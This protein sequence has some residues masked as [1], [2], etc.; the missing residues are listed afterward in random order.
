MPSNPHNTYKGKG[1]T[2]WG[3]FLGT[4]NLGSKAKQKS[5]ALYEEA[6]KVIQK[7]GIKS[8]REFNDWSKSGKRPPNIPSRPNNTYK[9]KGWTNWKDFLGPMSSR[10]FEYEEAKKIVS[11]EGIKYQNKYIEWLKSDK[12]PI[13]MPLKPERVYKGKGWTNWKDFLRKN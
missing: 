13:K 12:S 7:E 3:N 4:N 1:W 5:F 9:G 10:Y 8:F 6:K 2:S 11:E